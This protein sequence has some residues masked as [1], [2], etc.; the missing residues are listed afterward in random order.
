MTNKKA[1]GE[2]KKVAEEVKKAEKNMVENTTA[3]I[4]YTWDFYNN[5]QD[6]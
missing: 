1:T 3:V 4:I 6:E 2:A 5:L